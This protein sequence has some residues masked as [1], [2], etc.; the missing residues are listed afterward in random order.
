VNTG[1][2]YLSF[3]LNR[4]TTLEPRLGARWAVNAKSSLNAGIGMH[5]RTEAIPVYLALIPQAD[6]TLSALNDRLDFA[7]SLHYILGYDYSFSSDWRIKIEAYYQQLF[8]V[9]VEDAVESKKSAINYIY[10]VPDIGLVNSGKG[11]NY[12]T[13]F[14]L[15]RFYTSNY[16]L[17]ATVSVFDSRFKANDGKWY[18]TVF[19]SGYVTNLLAGRDFKFGKDQQ[20]TFGLNIK[21]FVRGGYRIS[22][23]DRE[24]S[25][26]E[27]DIVYNETKIYSK[28]L[29]VFARIDLGT[30]FRVNK[31]KYSYI[32]SADIQNITNRKNVMGYEYSD[33]A[34][35][36]VEVEGMGIVPIINFRIEM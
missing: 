3:A 25:L 29:P 8:D 28:Q 36:I 16:Y 32:I 18:N 2:H 14:T 10:G 24:K 34:Q 11:Y 21:G 26:A 13:E 35:D 27:H 17:L 7:K 33:K 6:G 20:N 9:P 12:G 4:H 23:I 22:P 1:L 5:S 19:N 15:E 30:Y 31:S